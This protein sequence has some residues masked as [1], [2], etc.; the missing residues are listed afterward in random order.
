ME[1]PIIFYG[2]FNLSSVINMVLV[3]LVVMFGC[4]FGVY[5]I[6]WGYQLL[7]ECIEL[8]VIEILIL[9]LNVIEYL[10]LKK[11]GLMV[12]KQY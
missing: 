11:S 7:I 9:V 5:Y 8:L 12:D 10:E 3:K 2:P 1:S 4:A 6:R